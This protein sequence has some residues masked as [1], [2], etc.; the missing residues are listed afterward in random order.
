MV[1]P[2]ESGYSFGGDTGNSIE[3]F[4]LQIHYH[5][6]EQKLHQFDS[7]GF[8]LFYTTQARDMRLGSFFG[9]KVEWDM[10]NTIPPG[11]KRF[12]VTEGCTVTGL[13]ERALLVYSI[14]HAHMLAREMFS[15]LYRA[16]GEKIPIY[17][18]LNWNFND[19]YSAR[20]KE[21]NITIFN[22]DVIQSTCVYDSTG[23]STHTAFG[24]R[25]QD[26]MCHGIYWIEPFPLGM[27]CASLG[28]WE[29]ELAAG[30]DGHTIRENHPSTQGFAVSGIQTMKKCDPELLHHLLESPEEFNMLLEHCQHTSGSDMD[31]RECAMEILELMACT[32]EGKPMSEFLSVEYKGKTMKALQRLVTFAESASMHSHLS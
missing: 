6:E 11:K 13:Q 20:V 1:A 18:D 12:F 21:K 19:Q 14:Y 28:Y 3:G 26:E 22:G 8:R 25:T 31:K 7:S 30:E 23:V 10:L 32:V 16:D 5:N 27:K 17:E 29:G 24:P 15:T 2:P 9:T 4:Q